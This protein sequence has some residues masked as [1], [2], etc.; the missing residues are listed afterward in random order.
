MQNIEEIET[1]LMEH[2]KSAKKRGNY[3]L[4][5]CPFHDDKNPS[6]AVYL[7]DNPH[8]HCFACGA[9]GSINE[10][11]DKLGINAKI[12]LPKAKII[13]AGKEGIEPFRPPKSDLDLLEVSEKYF[14]N[15]NGITPDEYMQGKKIIVN[16]KHDYWLNR[17]IS[18]DVLLKMGIGC[19]E[20]SRGFFYSL[21]YWW[22]DPETSMRT[23]NFE[24]VLIKKIYPNQGREKDAYG[25]YPQN[26]S[27]PLYHEPALIYARK[28]KL[29]I[30]IFEGE[31]DTLMAITHGIL[32]VGIA[33]K[34]GM[35]KSFIPLFK[36]IPE[37]MLWLDN[38]ADK[39]ME[40]IIKVF[41]FYKKRYKYQLPRIKKFN[42]ND[43]DLPKGGDFSDLMHLKMLK[44]RATNA[45]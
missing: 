11:F 42:W 22:I 26:T 38:D 23:S 3:I 44:R 39:E 36:G 30:G 14:K 29:K 28:N 33:G 24:I 19:G 1:L 40:Q 31:K 7:D 20:D 6:L 2:L 9:H 43:Y 41:E 37:V 34:N 45:Y 35:K 4:A 5:L 17:G 13:Q 27:I 16:S 25:I 10:L 18:L 12:D 32:G 21:P 15:L 8:Y